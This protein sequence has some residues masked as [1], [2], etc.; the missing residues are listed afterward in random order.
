MYITAVITHTTWQQ[1]SDH[2]QLLSQIAPHS[3][4]TFTLATK[5]QLLKKLDKS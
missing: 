5:I 2:Y 3:C 4:L 1:G